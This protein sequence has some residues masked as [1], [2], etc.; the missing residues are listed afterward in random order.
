MPSVLEKLPDENIAILTYTMP[1]TPQ[2]VQHGVEEISGVLET[3][4]GNLYSVVDV[5]SIHLSFS[6][7]VMGLANAVT[8][9]TGWKLSNE[10][11][12][13][14][15]V[16]AHSMI[17]LAVDA[18]KQRQYGAKNVTLFTDMNEALRYARQQG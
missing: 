9:K 13:L 4:E 5:Q 3:V 7:L 6:D 8:D 10:R 14:I 1:F 16:G 15:V 12:P 17:K 18:I 11:T 2:D